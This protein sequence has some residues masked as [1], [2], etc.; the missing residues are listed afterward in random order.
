MQGYGEGDYQH[1]AKE[2]PFC[3]P[4]FVTKITKQG[5]GDTSSGTAVHRNVRTCM[6]APNTHSAQKKTS[7]EWNCLHDVSAGTSCWKPIGDPII[8]DSQNII[9]SKF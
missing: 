3:S 9:S 4:S 7:W 8:A 6:G 2:K 5:F 1:T